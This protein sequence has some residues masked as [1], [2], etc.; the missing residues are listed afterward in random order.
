MLLN[1][2]SGNMRQM[3]IETNKRAIG[4]AAAAAVATSDL[5]KTGFLCNTQIHNCAWMA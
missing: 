4:V 2:R 5:L 1:S 3:Q